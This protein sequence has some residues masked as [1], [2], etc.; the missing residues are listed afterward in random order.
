MATTRGIQHYPPWEADGNHQGHPPCLP[1]LLT[2]GFWQQWEQQCRNICCLVLKEWFLPLASF[3]IKEWPRRQ[4]LGIFLSFFTILFHLASWFLATRRSAPCNPGVPSRC[5]V[6]EL[7]PGEEFAAEECEQQQGTTS[8]CSTSVC[9]LLASGLGAQ[10]SKK[11]STEYFNHL[12][13]KTKTQAKKKTPQN[14]WRGSTGTWEITLLSIWHVWQLIWCVWKQKEC[15]SA[16][17]V[18][19]QGWIHAFLQRRAAGRRFPW[20]HPCCWAAVI[21]DYAGMVSIGSQ[22]VDL[23]RPRVFSAGLGWLRSH[24][25]VCLFFFKGI[26]CVCVWIDGKGLF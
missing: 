9:S 15:L 10:T 24:C 3:G 14:C 22:P 5:R 23:P 19:H 20:C 4:N 8:A 2:G 25:S 21:G 16:A 26:W 13:K 1:W 6:W 11:N 17:H 18:V 7:G 12:K